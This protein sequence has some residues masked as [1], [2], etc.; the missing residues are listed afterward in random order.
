MLNYDAV[1]FHA[2]QLAEKYLKAFLQEHG[3]TIPYTHNLTDLLLLCVPI[4]ASLMSLDPDLRSLN[5]YAVRF[6]Y[7]GQTAN[8]TDA[9]DAFK[10]ASDIRKLLR[11]KLGL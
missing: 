1:C 5:G 10:A 11:Q 2:Q 4:D 7:P 9:K 8:R 6:R 3:I